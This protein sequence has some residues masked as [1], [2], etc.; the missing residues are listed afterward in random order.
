MRTIRRCSDSLD[1][2]LFTY[3]PSLNIGSRAYLLRAVL[4]DWDYNDA[5]RIL[6][7]VRAA[8]TKG[9]ST[10]LICDVILPA[11]GAQL[12]QAISD[13]SMMHLVSSSDRTEKGWLNLLHGAD[14]EVVK[15]WRHPA[16][17]DSILE[18]ALAGLEGGDTTVDGREGGQGT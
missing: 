2:F 9:Y 14:L 18:V 7:R 3:L 8:M 17:P 6:R 12:Y 13:F 15:I 1:W 5:K 10:L 4:H 11:V 16:S